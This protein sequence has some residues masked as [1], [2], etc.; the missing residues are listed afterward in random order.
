MIKAIIPAAGYGTRMNMPIDKSKEMLID[1]VTSKYLIDYSLDICYSNKIEPIVISRIEKEDL[2][3]YLRSK[4]VEHI[5]LKTPGKEWAETVM[6]SQGLWEYKN[7]LILPDT[8]FESVDCISQII[9]DLDKHPIS[10]ATHKIDPKDADKWGTIVKD[11]IEE[12]KA[13][14]SDKAWG[15]IGFTKNAGDM[16]FN[17]L[18]ATKTAS[19]WYLEPVTTELTK[20]VDITR[21]GKLEKY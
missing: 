10:I 4:G 6:K 18:I 20:F 8:R 2:N 14:G 9:K 5:V 11:N 7:I 1:P 12:K 21:S 17:Q 3:S 19:L 13:N 15:L 16:L